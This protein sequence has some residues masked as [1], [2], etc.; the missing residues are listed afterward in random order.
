ME[1]VEGVGCA[2]CTE[3]WKRRQ[4]K[5]QQEQYHEEKGRRMQARSSLLCVQV[6]YGARADVTGRAI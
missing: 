3:V 4:A 5:E 2:E 1:V 6:Q